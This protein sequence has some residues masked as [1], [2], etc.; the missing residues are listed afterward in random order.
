MPNPIVHFEII[1][2]DQQMLEAFYQQLFDWKLQPVMKGYTMV[3]TGSGIGG[4]IGVNSDTT[5]HVTFYVQ[6]ADV[7]ATLAQAEAQGGT[8]C[9][10]PH[11]IPDGSIIGGFF[12]PERHMIGVIQ[13]AGGMEAKS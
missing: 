9:W 4:G 12:D 5:S 6:V 13:P 3:N 10:G 8:R 11:T 2:K 1:G 7:E